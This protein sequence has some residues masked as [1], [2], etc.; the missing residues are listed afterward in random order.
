MSD[1]SAPSNLENVQ[2]TLIELD[3]A[4]IAARSHGAPTITFVSKELR[5]QGFAGCN[6]FSGGYQLDGSQLRI[7]PLATT[8]MACPDGSAETALLKALQETA[9]WKIDGRRLELLDGSAAARTRWT[10]TA[11]ETGEK[12]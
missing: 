11:I 9:S 12:P 7:G 4:A 10:V 2:W 1:D 3:G 8:R 6:R 5:A